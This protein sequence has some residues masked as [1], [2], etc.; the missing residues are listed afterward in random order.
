MDADISYLVITLRPDGDEERE[1]FSD[2]SDL[3]RYIEGRLDFSSQT[4]LRRIMFVFEGETIWN[5]VDV[6][7]G[8][9]KN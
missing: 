3:D 8:K 5:L 9:S 7:D 1:F 2:R 6:L 4:G